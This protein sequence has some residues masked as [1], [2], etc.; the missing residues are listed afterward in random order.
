MSRARILYSGI[1]VGMAGAAAVAVWFFLYDLAAGVPFRTPALLGAA[2]FDGL[3]D[4]A[5]LAITPR[6]V[7]KY[8]VVHGLAFLVFGVASAGLFALADNDRHALFLAFMLFCCFEVAMLSALMILESW[9]L[10]TLQPWAI[11]GA[12]LVAA[13]VMLGMLF[14]DHHMSFAELLTSGE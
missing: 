10:N 2:L 1:L 5:A 7:L 13:V 8:S 11:L 3:R 4:P 6:L 9:L 12:N 14:R